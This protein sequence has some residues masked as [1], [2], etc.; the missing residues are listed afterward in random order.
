[1]AV[2][3]GSASMLLYTLN[4]RTIQSRA[5]VKLLL[6]GRCWRDRPLGFCVSPAGGRVVCSSC[7]LRLR[8]NGASCDAIGTTSA[9]HVIQFHA[10]WL[11]HTS[12]RLA[13]RHSF[14]ALALFLKL[15]A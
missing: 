12:S 6:S 1:M 8:G 14:P 10:A 5:A 7:C 11:I 3:V 9:A 15:T 13:V 4:D 2:G